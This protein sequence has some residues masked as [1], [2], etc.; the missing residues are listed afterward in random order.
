V[1]RVLDALFGGD[2]AGLT[3][4]LAFDEL[5]CTVEPQLGGAPQCPPG[6]ADGSVV[7]AFPAGQGCQGSW[8]N[9][10]AASDALAGLASAGIRLY[11]V[12]RQHPADSVP[13][14]LLFPRGEYVIVLAF[15]ADPSGTPGSRVVHITG[16]QIVTIG[17]WCTQTLAERVAGVPSDAFLLPPP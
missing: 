1:D 3:G 2:V 12:Y 7:R 6:L 10:I 8:V 4:L 16:H 11:A 15:P 13:A 5:P 17:G 9:E 14:E